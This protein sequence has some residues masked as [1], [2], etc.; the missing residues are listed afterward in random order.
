MRASVDGE[1]LYMAFQGFRARGSIGFNS[2]LSGMAYA[3]SRLSGSHDAYTVAGF[4]ESLSSRV[5]FFFWL[6][7]WDP[8]DLAYMRREL[9]EEANGRG[10]REAFFWLSVYKRSPY[11]PSPEPDEVYEG[12]RRGRRLPYL[13][14]YPMKKSPEWYLE[15]AEERRK[16]MAE[17]IAIARR[18][19]EEARGEVRSYTTYTFGLAPWEFLVVYEV[20]DLAEWTWIVEELRRARARRW[21]VLESPVIVGLLHPAFK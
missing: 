7:A 16:V 2:L 3:A 8:K 6:A 19:V 17:H 20:E 5:D 12:L 1:P 11:Y 15:P 10:A 4:Y 14:F 13:V 9:K 18:A 21:V